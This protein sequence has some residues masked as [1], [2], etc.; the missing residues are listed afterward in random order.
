MMALLGAFDL[1]E[2][3]VAS[4]IEVAAAWERQQAWTAAQAQKALASIVGDIADDGSAKETQEWEWRSD[5]TAAALGWSPCTAANRLA[6]ARRLTG[7]LQPT[8]DLLESGDISFRHAWLLTDG[9]ADLSAEE[10]VFVQ[11]RV[12]ENA[13][14]ETA[15]AFGRRVKRAVLAAAPELAAARRARAIECERSVRVRSGNDGM[16][17]LVATM[18]AE[19][20]QTVYEALDACARKV[21][22]DAEAAIRAHGCADAAEAGEGRLDP[23]WWKPAV[24]KQAL[25]MDG[26]RVDALVAWAGDALANPELPRRQGRRVEL[27]VVVDLASLLGLADNPAELVGYGP[28][29]AEAAR[30]LAG[31]ATWRRLV[32]DPADGHLLDYGAVIYRPPQK[33]ADYIVARDR[34]CRFPGC[35]RR[36]EACDIDHVCPHGKA[37]GKTAACNCCT[38]CR[39]HHRAKTHLGWQLQ[40][41][42][43]DS[44][45]W[46]AP[47]GHIFDVDLEGQLE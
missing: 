22:A 44:A 29:P 2:L 36:A 8:F 33:L 37:G 41:H 15:A 45:T 10:R 12:L 1:A 26:L 20:A 32:T 6:V 28:I 7:E 35:G 34:R 4:R 43:D 3:D 24:A 21:K 42:P 19:E 5:C 39:R 18:T 11:G 9:V 13:P 25:R 23:D 46:T 27:Q 31:D 30:E 38:L 14:G 40:L 47:S 17:S 16:A